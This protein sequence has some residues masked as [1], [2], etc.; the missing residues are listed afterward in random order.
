ML[1]T[2]PGSVWLSCSYF[3]Y[4]AA[5]GCLGPYIGLYYRLLQLNGIQIGFLVAIP[6]LG[7]AVLAPLWGGFADTYSAHRLVL[8]ATLLIAALSAL[9]IAW[10]TSFV[11]L[12]L[13]TVLL[14]SCLAAIPALLDSYAV[15][16]SERSG[17]SYGQ[18]R[19]WG[20]IGFIVGV[21][22]VG[23]QMGQNI[24]HFFLLAYTATL[25][26]TC[27]ATFGLPPL[28][29]SSTQPM[30]E[31]VSEILHDRSVTLVLLTSFLVIGNATM[32]GSYFGIYLTE[33]GGSVR[34]VGTASVLAA[35]SEVPIMLFGRRF[36]ERFS[37]RKIL[38]FAV[39][40]YTIRL[41]LY[42]LPPAAAWVIWVQLLHGM[43]FGLY[44]MASVTLVHQLAGRE[45]AATAQGLLSSSSQGFGAITGAL[46]GGVL[47]DQMGAVGIMRV[48]SVG[49]FVALAI[50][51]WGGQIVMARRAATNSVLKP[52]Q[53]QR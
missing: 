38:I 33:I 50:C 25:L 34:L 4:L 14:A 53:E 20:T 17:L 24:S 12:L 10:T 44:L 16:I 13:L 48:A 41:L 36:I 1:R 22:F 18:F 3:W 27:G 8:R 51:L 31:C 2:V 32:M 52:S 28:R 39:A 21:W 37:S 15:T 6:P 19:V 43:S 9:L 29:R 47:L 11:P 40:M 26:I 5:I 49:M 46:I 23:W 30:W 45:R 35:V 42:S 7:I